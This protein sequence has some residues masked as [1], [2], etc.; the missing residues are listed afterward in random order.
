MWDRHYWRSK[1]PIVVLCCGLAGFLFGLILTRWVIWWF[2][3]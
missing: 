3:P 1:R 2:F